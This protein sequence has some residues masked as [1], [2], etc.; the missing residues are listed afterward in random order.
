MQSCTHPLLA[1]A[2]HLQGK[3]L[4]RRVPPA[5]ADVALQRCERAVVPGWTEQL[6]SLTIKVR[7]STVKRRG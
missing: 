4:L 6:Q 7:A 3:A 2:G 5:A 1:A